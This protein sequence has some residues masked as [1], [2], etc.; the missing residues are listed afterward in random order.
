MI[1]IYT[2]RTKLHHFLKNF[3]EDL[4]NPVMYARLLLF[5][6]KNNDTKRSTFPKF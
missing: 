5:A 3:S 4:L 1:K 2:T 6:K